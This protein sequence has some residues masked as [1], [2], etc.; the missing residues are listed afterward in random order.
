MAL[1]IHR[2]NGAYSSVGASGAIN[3]L[4]FAT[5]ALFPDIRIF[6]MPGW[7]YG[8]IY[9]LY[10]IYGIRSQK[11]N[12]G[13]EAHLGGAVI[14]ML[15]AIVF[16][17]MALIQHWWVFVLVLTPV[18]FFMFIIIKKPQALLVENLFYQNDHNY[19]LDDRYNIEQKSTQQ[20]VDRIL[21]K[22]HKKG[23]SSLSRKEKELL[24][25]FS[26]K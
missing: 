4:L 7:L 15:T 13:H 17:P 1:F 6:F 23:M 26:K 18:L 5:I 21:E 2:Y 24:D 22:I 25:E 14:G 9:A 19:T 10:S 3:G 12:I 8:L 20:E 11:T 16:K